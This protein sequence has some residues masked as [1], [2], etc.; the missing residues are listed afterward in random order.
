MSLLEK[1]A[2]NKK[3]TAFFADG[4]QKMSLGIAAVV[5][6]LNGTEKVPVQ[7]APV[8][9]ASC[10]L[11]KLV[12]SAGRTVQKAE[13]GVFLVQPWTE[14]VSEAVEPKLVEVVTQTEPVE[15]TEPAAKVIVRQDRKYPTL[16][17]T[18]F[19][20]QS[21]RPNSIHLEDAGSQPGEAGRLH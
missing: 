5:D 6:L 21:P 1:L 8:Q 11:T 18:F 14:P 20:W 3:I 15:R 19:Q 2:I 16:S 7:Q 4:S 9:R 10:L 12:E 17:R 13:E